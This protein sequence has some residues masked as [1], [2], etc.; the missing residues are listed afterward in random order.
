M[1]PGGQ[2]QAKAGQEGGVGPV[3]E[4]GGRVV[5]VQLRHAWA[6]AGALNRTLIIPELYCGLDRYWAA[7]DGVIPGSKFGV[8]FICPLD[9]VL[10]LEQCAPRPSTCRCPPP[11][12]P[13]LHPQHPSPACL[14]ACMR[15]CASPVCACQCP[16]GAS[17]ARASM[18]PAVVVAARLHMLA[19]PQ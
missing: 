13:L 9:H 4:K 11:L 8:P 17:R 19:A 2:L 3:S 7:H 15:A 18:P 16:R 10:D 14:P 1:K 12:P 5:A 6:I